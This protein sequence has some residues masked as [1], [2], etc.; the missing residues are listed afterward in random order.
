MMP[1]LRPHLTA[2]GLC[3]RP[4]SPMDQLPAGARSPEEIASFTENSFMQCCMKEFTWL[5]LNSKQNLSVS[6]IVTPSL[7]KL[8]RPLLAPSDQFSRSR[9]SADYADF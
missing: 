4:S 2:L 3:G 1:A 6:H 8:F 5:H 7:T 9:S